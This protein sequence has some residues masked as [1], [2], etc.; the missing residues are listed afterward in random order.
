MRYPNQAME[1]LEQKKN[2]KH[3]RI[4]IYEMKDMRKRITL[5]III[6]LVIVDIALAIFRVQGVPRMV[7][8]FAIRAFCA[9]YITYQYFKNRNTINL[10]TMLVFIYLLLSYIYYITLNYPAV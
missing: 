5:I 4:K 10:L 3:E 6:L 7:S 1:G 8:S 9:V 2:E